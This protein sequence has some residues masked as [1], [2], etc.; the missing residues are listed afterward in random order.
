MSRRP[1][2]WKL[3][4]LELEVLPIVQEID[5]RDGYRYVPTD[6]S[7]ISQACVI[8]GFATDEITAATR[9]AGWRGGDTAVI[10]LIADHG[11]AVREIARL[12]RLHDLHGDI[13]RKLC[14]LKLSAAT[15]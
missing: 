14:G 15:A 11:N 13:P 9:A 5:G 2:T 12:L 3:A 7:Q 1:G 4:G 10:S 6:A 8:V